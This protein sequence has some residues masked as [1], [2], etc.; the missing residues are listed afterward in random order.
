[1]KPL[2]D[3]PLSL[4][5]DTYGPYTPEEPFRGE[6]SAD[7]AI[8]GGGFSG[9]ATAYELK[10]AQPSLRIVVL[11][12]KTIGYGASGRN[13]SF[14]MTVVGLGFG[15]MAMLRGKPFTKKAHAYMEKAVDY[16]DDFI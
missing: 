5:L 12:A 7:I 8:I 3:S 15:T 2:P 16:L 14:A 9:L 1:M 4:W 6:A 10:R 13:G 11:E